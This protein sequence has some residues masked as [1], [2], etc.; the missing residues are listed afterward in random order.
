MAEKPLALITYLMGE[1]CQI[2][3]NHG[4]VRGHALQREDGLWVRRAADGAGAAHASS[5]HAAG[6]DAPCHEA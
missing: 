2:S 6:I 1:S 4:H 3:S 5:H